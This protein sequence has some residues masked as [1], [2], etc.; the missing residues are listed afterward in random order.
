MLQIGQALT[1]L[2]AFGTPQLAV[3]SDADPPFAKGE[4]MYNQWALEL[5]SLQSHYR[6]GILQEG[7]IR[8][9]KGDVANMVQF[10]GPVASIKAILD[11]LD[12][13]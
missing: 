10:L 2:G 3:F 12:L 1:T 13:L 9:L 8:S 11:T 4:S 7:I 5:H 6:E